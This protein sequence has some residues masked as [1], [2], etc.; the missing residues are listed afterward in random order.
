MVTAGE[1][2]GVVQTIE[3]EGYGSVTLDGV[4]LYLQQ[5][6]TAQVTATGNTLYGGGDLTA[7]VISVRDGDAVFTGNHCNQ[8]TGKDHP[9]VSVRAA[10]ATVQANRV[11]G[12]LPSMYLSVGVDAAVVLGNITSGDIQI[13]G[14]PVSQTGKPWSQLNALVP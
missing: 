6:A 8:P 2:G 4:W 7:A 11:R 3:I 9:A 12:G 14:V 10:S 5:E 13:N 1:E